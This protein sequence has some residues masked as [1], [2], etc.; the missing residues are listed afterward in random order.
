MDEHDGTTAQMFGLVLRHLRLQTGLSQR[1]LGKL[2]LYDHT[3]ISRTE[4]GDILPPA[5]KVRLLD[6]ALKA[7]GLLLALSDTARLAQ[8]RPYSGSV[9]GLHDGEPVMLD[10]QTPDGRNVRVTISR[11]QFAQLLASGTLSAVLPGLSESDQ[12]QRVARALQEPARVDAGVIDYFRRVLA[13]HYTADKMLGP[14]S[15]L[16]PV[17]AQIEVLDELRRGAG[18]RHAE[19]LLQVLAQY[20]EMAGWL[21]QDLGEL[22]TAMEWTRQA[23]EWAMCA[24]DTQ[25]T[26]YLL[27]RQSNIAC[28]TDDY[29]AVVHLAAAARRRPDELEPKLDALAAQQ[30]ARGLVMLGE[31]DDCFALLDHAGETLRDHPQ[32]TH[33]HVPVYLHH[34]DSDTLQEQSAVC[35]RAAGRADTAVTILEDQIGKLPETLARDRGHLTAK[36][37]V[38]VAQ[39][40]PDPARAAHLGH[41]ALGVARRTGS[42]RIR[43]ELRTLDRELSQ[44]W[45]ADTQ[46]RTFHEALASA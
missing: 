7:G 24:G 8:A 43:R 37:A 17:L 2:S 31:H 15:L 36:L 14:R 1:E 12:A 19:P 9:A 21:H 28:L 5:D 26:A 3:R 41:E 39:S 30:Q 42:V 32:V 4:N 27:V 16:R 20:G 6:G 13:E 25:M 18:A 44:R 23:A 29:A 10:M 11:R 45:P 40:Q 33:P 46:A 22:D 35:Y 34:Y 38:A